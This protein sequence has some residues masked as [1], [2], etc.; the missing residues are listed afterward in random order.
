MTTKRRTFSPE[1]KREAADFILDNRI[2][3]RDAL[4]G[5]ETALIRWVSQPS[6]ERRNQG[7]SQEWH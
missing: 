5:G 4:G 6:S 3:T 1:F 2:V 7:G